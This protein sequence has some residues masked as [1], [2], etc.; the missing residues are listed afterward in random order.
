[1]LKYLLQKLK[2]KF[3]FGMQNGMLFTL[4]IEHGIA[5]YKC[6]CFISREKKYPSNLKVRLIPE[7]SM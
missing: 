5:K 1:M 4:K 7:A 3:D 2:Y 6:S